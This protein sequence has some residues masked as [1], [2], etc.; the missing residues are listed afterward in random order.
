[1]AG[2]VK[3]AETDDELRACAAVLRELRPTLSEAQLVEQIALQRAE[4]Y[5]VAMLKADGEVRTVAGFRVQLMLATG[6]TMYVDDLVTT[7]T[8]RSHGYGATMLRWLRELARAEGCATFSLDSG[9]QR[10]EAHAFYLRERLRIT[11]FH[12]AMP[13]PG[14]GG[15]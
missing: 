8:G 3:L 1:M 6:R 11:S 5:R 9:T 13:L 10:T 14:H 7:A 15:S 12:F 4:G 2:Q